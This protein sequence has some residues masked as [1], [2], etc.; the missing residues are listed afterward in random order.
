M[1]DWKLVHQILTFYATHI[2][3]L[4]NR[5]SYFIRILPCFTVKLF[6]GF[7]WQKVKVQ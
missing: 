2:L 3:S 5:E 4:L 1:E 7:A 6:F